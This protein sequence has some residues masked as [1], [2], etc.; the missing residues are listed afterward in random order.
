MLKEQ[1]TAVKK[2]ED[3]LGTVIAQMQFDK[4]KPVTV[5][6]IHRRQW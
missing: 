5:N 3:E 1:A 4:A 6:H 2:R